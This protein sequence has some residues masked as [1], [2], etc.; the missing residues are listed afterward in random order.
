MAKILVYTGVY[1][2]IVFLERT[3]RSVLDQSFT[4]FDFV[5]S[6][7]HSTDGSS[8]LI[9]RFAS[10][11]S[12]IKV[13]S[14]PSFMTSLDHGQFIVS[15]LRGRDY[16]AALYIGGHDVISPDYLAVMYA[17]LVQHPSCAI[18]YPKN[19][20]EVDA[21]DKVLKQWGSSPQTVGVPQPFRTICA[22]LTLVHNIPLF[23]LWR[24]EVFNSCGDLPRCMGGDHLFV[25][26]ALLFGDLLEVPQGSLYLRRAAGADDLSTY[27]QKHLGSAVNGADDLLA[28]LRYLGDVVNKACIGYPE[29][30][31]NAVRASATLLYTLR[32]NHLLTTPE[33]REKFF[34]LPQ[35]NAAL[36]ACIQSGVV[37]GSLFKDS[38]AVC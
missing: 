5:I 12:R 30:T 21:E 17:W 37:L 24:Y 3:I 4:D 26:R 32:F 35:L 7:N 28:Q 34:S 11:D 9:Q 16:A 36:G 13:I 27:K 8:D 1:N 19:A 23:G 6:D 2:E 33:E 31:I 18:V 38:E 15:S 14:P 20:F 25:A 22:L 10:A 29:S